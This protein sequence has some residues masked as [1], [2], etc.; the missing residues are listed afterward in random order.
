MKKTEY[1]NYIQQAVIGSGY[2]VLGF[3][4]DVLDVTTAL[5]IVKVRTVLWYA[6]WKG[7]RDYQRIL[8]QCLANSTHP[9]ICRTVIT[10]DDM[11]LR[12]EN[13]FSA[14]NDP[15]VRLPSL[16][17]AEETWYLYGGSEKSFERALSTASTRK[18]SLKGETFTSYAMTAVDRRF[19]ETRQMREITRSATEEYRIHQTAPE[20]K[21]GTVSKNGHSA[22]LPKS[23]QKFRSALLEAFRKDAQVE[24]AE[25]MARTFHMLPLD[26]GDGEDRARLNGCELYQL[27]DGLRAVLIPKGDIDKTG[28]IHAIQVLPGKKYYTFHLNRRGVYL[29][30]KPFLIDGTTLIEELQKPDLR[31]YNKELLGRQLKLSSINEQEAVYESGDGV[32]KLVRMKGCIKME[33]FNERYESSGENYHYFGKNELI[34][35]FDEFIKKTG[36][37]NGFLRRISQAELDN[38]Y[39]KAHK[40]KFFW[41]RT[42]K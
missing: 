29:N 20:K 22:E 2:T 33:T 32:F 7:Q 34:P 19:R 23:G 11:L 30:E 25:D 31:E 10:S 15:Y 12:L 21:R 24:A 6:Y 13:I 1:G 18:V 5:L 9:S 4:P 3:T 40:R 8:T 14:D 39:N 38:R 16:N 41:Q 42:N 27:S 17:G 35:T 37:G 36:Y 28:I 26:I